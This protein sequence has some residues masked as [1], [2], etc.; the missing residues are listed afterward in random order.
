M[1]IRKTPTSTQH[2]PRWPL[3]RAGAVALMAA[4][5]TAVTNLVEAQGTLQARSLPNGTRVHTVRNSD[6][7]LGPDLK[8]P[9][10]PSERDRVRAFYRDVLG[11]AMTKESDR[12]DIFRIGSG[13]YLG[14]VYDSS[15]QRDERRRSLWLEVRVDH[16]E[17]LERKIVA[18]GAREIDFFDKM[19]FYFQAPGGQV[20]RLIGKDEDMSSWQR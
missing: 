18:F 17:E 14:V 7:S 12:A 19:H 5:T 4:A 11:C 16:P 2:S 15:A 10:N 6:I 3:S 9:V 8:L 20:F 1:I 13:S